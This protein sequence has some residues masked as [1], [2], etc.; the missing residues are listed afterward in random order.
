M[1]HN[2]GAPRMGGSQRGGAS[3]MGELARTGEV[4]KRRSPR[5][6]GIPGRVQGGGYRAVPDWG[7]PGRGGATGRGLLVRGSQSLPLE[8]QQVALQDR[9]CAVR[10][11]A[12]HPGQGVA[13]WRGGTKAVRE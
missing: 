7:V 9:E 10:E 11:G 8:S 12:W 13:L 2:R 6:S 3:V 5:I 4:P 1:S